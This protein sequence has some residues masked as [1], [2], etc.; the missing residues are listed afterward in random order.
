M[1]G[2]G[3]LAV[4]A[5]G[6]WPEPVDDGGVAGEWWGVGGVE[7]SVDEAGERLGRHLDVNLARR[8]RRRR[9]EGGALGCELMVK[10]RSGSVVRT[11]IVAGSPT[12]GGL[13][14]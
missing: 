9:C 11:V 3:R 12:V 4:M 7:A 6:T 14:V 8:G 13:A 2:A 10:Y 5:L 1:V